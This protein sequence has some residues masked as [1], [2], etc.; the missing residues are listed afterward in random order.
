MKGH[1]ADRDSFL[2]VFSRRRVWLCSAE[3]QT[4]EFAMEMATTE[5]RLMG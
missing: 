1:V 5:S 4:L 2:L 3:R